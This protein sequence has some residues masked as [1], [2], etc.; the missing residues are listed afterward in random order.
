M[1]TYI[2]LA[3]AFV[4]A[5]VVPATPAR[6]AAATGPRIVV[7]VR[8]IAR[9]EVVSMAD[10]AFVPAASTQPGTVRAMKDVV[11]LET[12]RALRTGES[13]RAQ[14]FRHPIVV[15]KGSIVTM[16]YDV[17]GITLT[18][19]MRAIGS[20]GVGETVTVQNPVSFRQVGAII[21]GPGQVQALNSAGFDVSAQVSANP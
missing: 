1:K 11:G 7:P 2:F 15:N 12:R 4:L 5:A 21:T 16:T 9:G 17:P 18:A 8:D 6:A 20:G 10:F 3:L 13:L 14:D 19:S